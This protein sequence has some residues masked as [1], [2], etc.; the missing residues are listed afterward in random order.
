M[1]KLDNIF[2]EKQENIKNQ[3]N[4]ETMER[5]T[6]RLWVAEVVK[7]HLTAGLGQP[8]MI[9]VSS[10]NHGGITSIWRLNTTMLK[11]ANERRNNHTS[12]KEVMLGCDTCYYKCIRGG[13]VQW[14][15]TQMLFP[16][17]LQWLI[18]VGIGYFRKS[19][20]R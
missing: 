12:L 9:S 5:L 11:T 4:L 19:I 7:L 1:L 17:L 18:N 3:T 6:E 2:G 13:G 14:E 8:E 10:R 20:S 16:S 15:G